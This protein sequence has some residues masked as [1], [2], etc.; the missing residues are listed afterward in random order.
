[1]ANFNNELKDYQSIPRA[2]IFD[3]D[4]SDRARFLFCY[5]ASKPDNWNF[6]I[7]NMTKELGY[8]DET[9]RKYI[10]ELISCGWLIKGE[11]SNLGKFGAV[12]YT[13]KA[14]KT[15]TE[16]CDTEKIRYGENPAHK[17]KDNYKEKDNNKEIYISLWKTD[18]NAYK[19]LVLEANKRLKDDLEFKASQEK[20]FPNINYELS[21]DKGCDYWISEQGYKKAKSTKGILNMYSRLKNNF[22]KNKVYY[23][24][25]QKR[26]E[27]IKV[28]ENALLKTMNSDGE[29]SDGTR[30]INGYRQYYSGRWNRVVNIPLDA[31]EKP[32]SR[33]IEYDKDLKDWYEP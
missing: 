11:Q 26:E 32:R 31:P 20:Y 3:N 5:M 28:I 33:T 16:K 15:D 17:E 29:L 6:Y 14:K 24:K 12:E 22:D 9:L 30:V 23:A 1:M 2:L 18:F 4:M 25:G 13:L 19:Q 7:A 21:I 10:N 8:S 27:P